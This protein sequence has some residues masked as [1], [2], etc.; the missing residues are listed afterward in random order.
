M[1]SIDVHSGASELTLFQPNYTLSFYLISFQF[2]DF[3]CHLSIETRVAVK[4]INHELIT[5][6]GSRGR[7]ENF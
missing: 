7:A 1:V 3:Q 4:K 6:G 5:N 2:I